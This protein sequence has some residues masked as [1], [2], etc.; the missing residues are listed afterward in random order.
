MKKYI[1]SILVLFLSIQFTGCSDHTLEELSSDPNNP[2]VVTPTLLLT[3]AQF[4]VLGNYGY[5]WDRYAG[6]FVQ[7]FAGNHATGVNA[8]QY[9]LQAT[10]FQ[11]DYTV[12]YRQGFK[13]AYDIINS[14]GPAAGADHHIGVAKIVMA[15]GLGYL[16]DVYGDI[17]YT[18]AWQ[19]NTF[20]NPK[21]DSQEDIYKTINTLLTE[22][23]ADLQK[24]PTLPLAGDLVH[25]N[26][27][28]KWIGTAYL[29][30][31]RYANH[32]S[33]VDPAGSATKALGY[34]DA[35]KAAGFTSN[36]WNYSLKFTN[37]DPNWRNPWL[38]LYENNLIIASE[39]FMNRLTSSAYGS[40]DPRRFE[41][42]NFTSFG[43]G[44]PYVGFTGKPNGDPTGNA[45]YSPVGPGGYYGKTESPQLIGTYYELLF[46]EAEAALRATN[47]GRAATAL[48]AA[49]AAQ[50][51]MVIGANTYAY[52][53]AYYNGVHNLGLSAATV[54]AVI[55]SRVTA[56][57]AFNAA[58]A[59]NVTME[60]IMTEKYI[61]MFTM[62][63]ETWV[64]VRRH[65]W[66]Y[67]TTLALPN[68]AFLST[69]ISRGLYPQSSLENNSSTP[70]GV[71]MTDKLWWDK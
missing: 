61:A 48:N 51:D 69:F 29:L 60:K 10:D 15:S 55:D 33:Q 56:Y 20:K 2:S 62:N 18:E 50:F 25:G 43:A 23:I 64:D 4:Q 30:L 37:T 70:K 54:K 24:T 53:D 11:G 31:A 27:P 71:K 67:P 9:N 39:S 6:A 63:L 57:K 8:D 44:N 13:D 19:I 32:L 65:D 66:Q 38:N 49:V 14:Q 45:S 35:A 36:S 41:Y 34:V 17:P 5:G 26:N 68:N 40:F 21:F 58:T 52:T 42:F 12:T 3:A 1:Y 22:A 28:Q 46:I 59:A 7:T 16:T 47:P